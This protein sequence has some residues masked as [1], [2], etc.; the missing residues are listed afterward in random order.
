MRSDPRAHKPPAL[1]V[2]EA[3]INPRQLPLAEPTLNLSY[4]RKGLRLI[5]QLKHYFK[6]K[7]LQPVHLFSFACSAGLGSRAVAAINRAINN[8]Q[9]IEPSK[10]FAGSQHWEIGTTKHAYGHHNTLRTCLPPQS[11]PS[12]AAGVMGERYRMFVQLCATCAPLLVAAALWN[13][14]EQ[15]FPNVPDHIRAISPLWPVEF[16]HSKTELEQLFGAPNSQIRQAIVERD[17]SR[18]LDVLACWS[19]FSITLGVSMAA[20]RPK[21]RKLAFVLILTS[22]GFL[23][24]RNHVLDLTVDAANAAVVTD[25]LVQ[26]IHRFV[27]LQWSLMFVNTL[28]GSLLFLGSAPEVKSAAYLLIVSAIFGIIGTA[29]Y[30]PLI[31]YAV[32]GILFAVAGL[33]LFCFFRPEMV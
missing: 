7:S 9:M 26:G 13:T 24:V 20:I 15:V 5:A 27:L 29:V 14:T 4:D 17:A 31:P 18:K 6:A 1:Q 3:P 19:Y 23:F 22:V 30:N 16:V 25:G 21:L 12:C 2:V 33:A 32:L 28:F 11:S 8:N 10:A